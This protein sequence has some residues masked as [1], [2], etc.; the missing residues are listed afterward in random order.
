MCELIYQFL[1]FVPRRFRGVDRR[2]PAFLGPVSDS[3]DLAG[4]LVIVPEDSSDVT[5]VGET[6]TVLAGFLESTFTKTH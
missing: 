1:V 2:A 6:L 5:G 4:V 3:V